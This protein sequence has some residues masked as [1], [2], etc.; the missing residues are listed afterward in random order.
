MSAFIVSYIC[1][2]LFVCCLS[3]GICVCS[4]VNFTAFV[5]QEPFGRVIICLL[6]FLCL[7]FCVVYNFAEE[8]AVL[9][10]NMQMSSWQ[11]YFFESRL[12]GII[13]G[14]C[15]H[16]LKKQYANVIRANLLF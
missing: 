11:T 8:L 9:K 10:N 12:P 5:K 1:I 7:L 13:I 6:L 14:D 15:F 4:C 2:F 3:Y 16:E